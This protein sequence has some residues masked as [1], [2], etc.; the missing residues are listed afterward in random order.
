MSPVVVIGFGALDEALIA[1]GLY[2]IRDYRRAAQRTD[3]VKRTN[4]RTPK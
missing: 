4:E 1:Q 3:T 2:G